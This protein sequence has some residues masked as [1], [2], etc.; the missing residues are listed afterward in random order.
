MLRRR[1]IDGE[2]K[3]R[4]VVFV[5][6]L[7]RCAPSEVAAT[8]EAIRT[9]LGV[10]GCIFIVAADQQ[11]LEHALT[12]KLRQLT[13]PDPANPYYSAGSAYLDKIFQYQLSFP[14]LRPRRLTGFA[15]KLVANRGGVWADPAID[16]E[17]VVSILL[18]THIHSPRRVKVLLNAFAL[19]YGIAKARAERNKL[20]EVSERAAE[21]AKLVCIELEFPLFARDLFLDER[22]AVAVLLSARAKEGDEEAAAGLSTLPGRL[23]HLGTLYS[24]GKLPV[25]QLLSGEGEEQGGVMAGRGGQTATDEE[26][27][28]DEEASH[29]D[30]AEGASEREDEEASDEEERVRQEHAV[31]LVRYLEKTETVEGPRSDLIHLE[32]AGAVWNLR[33]ADC[34]EPRTRRARQQGQRRRPPN[35]GA[36]V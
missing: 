36:V 29:E 20:A 4:L 3:N 13:P 19:S 12:E 9:F 35:R 30:L 2:S 34:A 17:D 1:E 24:E 11:V 7:D 5:D 21:L 32:S 33:C 23:G 16:K 25:A 28:R 14:P 26:R 15:L 22:L 10:Q 27:E 18:P 6:E 8:L 31:Q